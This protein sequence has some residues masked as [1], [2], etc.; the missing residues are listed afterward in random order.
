LNEVA[1]EENM[2]TKPFTQAIES[3]IDKAVRDFQ[4]LGFNFITE[5]DLQSCLF[6]YLRHEK[7]LSVRCA[8]RDVN[9]V[10][11]EFPV[12]WENGEVGNRYDLVVW[13]PE[14]LS[15][16]DE[17]ALNDLWGSGRTEQARKIP[18][19]AAIEIKYFYGGYSYFKKHL[20]LYGKVKRHNDVVKLTNG[21]SRYCYFLGFSDEDIKQ[22]TDAR[23]YFEK[24][25][26]SFRRAR[27]VIG[28]RLR[29]LC[30][31]RDGYDEIRIGFSSY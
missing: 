19:L 14:F 18:L 1:K 15:G 21:K 9:L 25:R 29:V 16:L 13:D 3:C 17:D 12:M 5:S 24:M 2:N 27:Q 30:V 8:G 23:R 22:N 7:I 6:G 20:S 4:E 10:H 11:S 31:S 26:D 28:R